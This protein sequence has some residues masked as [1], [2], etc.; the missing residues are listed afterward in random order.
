MSPQKLKGSS[1]VYQKG[2]K[3]WHSGKQQEKEQKRSSMWSKSQVSLWSGGVKRI[4]IR[5]WSIKGHFLRK[6]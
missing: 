2:K 6:L 4:F 5:N 1:R 3:G